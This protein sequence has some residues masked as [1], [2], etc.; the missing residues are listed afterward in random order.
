[1]LRSTEHTTVFIYSTVTVTKIQF[2]FNSVSFL[3]NIKILPS[4]YISY[5]L[6]M[7]KTIDNVPWTVRLSTIKLKQN[8]TVTSLAEQSNQFG[9]QF[10]QTRRFGHRNLVDQPIRQIQIYRNF[11]QLKPLTNLSVFFVCLKW[12]D[13]RG[14]RSNGIGTCAC[15]AIYLSVIKYAERFLEAHPS[16]SGRWLTTP[17]KFSCIIVRRWTVKQKMQHCLGCGSSSLPTWICWFG[18]LRYK[19]TG[20]FPVP[21]FTHF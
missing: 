14:L 15:A 20:A 13:W 3:E 1:M 10:G 6:R 18:M 8:V 19:R 9:Q 7:L 16:I 21:Y 4:R 11:W 12:K 17:V 2:P 5:R